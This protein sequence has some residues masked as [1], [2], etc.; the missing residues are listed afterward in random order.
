MHFSIFRPLCRPSVPFISPIE[1]N[2]LSSNNRLITC[3]KHTLWHPI[4]INIAFITLLTISLYVTALAEENQT[5]AP[6]K[7]I[8]FEI[9]IKT[10]GPIPAQ[11]IINKVFEWKIIVRWYGANDSINPRIHKLPSF[12]NLKLISQATSMLTGSDQGR[13]YAEKIF[14]FK[15]LPV[16]EGDASIGA[17]TVRYAKSEEQNDNFLTTA[18]STLTIQPAPFSLQKWC[19]R[20]W[21]KT[22]F[23]VLILIVLITIIFCVTL[24]L[25]R[26]R[27]KDIPQ[28]IEEKEN[29]ADVALQAAR[30]YR[31]E[32][33]RS[34]YI[35]QLKNAVLYSFT[36]RFPQIKSTDLMDFH[37]QIDI[38]Q[39]IILDRFIENSEHLQ[40]APVSSSADQLDRVMQDARNLAGLL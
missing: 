32:G 39:Q 1:T 6:D 30:R 28:E 29:P 21:S 5:I 18:S 40:F 12:D 14:I 23:K 38:E 17:A 31:I 22:W 16:S 24:A 36:E 19:S 2:W 34:S 15:I 13:R 26:R 4:L 7:E 8:D 3:L 25:Y 20:Q 35:K 11:T 9:T 37:D 10:D 33:D 27:N